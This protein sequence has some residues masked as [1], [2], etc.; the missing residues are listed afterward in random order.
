MDRY[1][2]L[3]PLYDVVSLERPI[4]RAGRVAAVDALRLQPGQTVLVVGSGTGLST[5]LLASHLGPLGHIVGVDAN[6]DMLK[7]AE[8][9]ADLATRQCSITADATTLERSDLP[10]GLGEIHAVLF[11]Y[12]LS[13]MDPW[14]AAWRAVTALLRPGAA[15]AVAD[16]TLPHRGGVLAR[17]AARLLCATGG[18]DIS[19]HPWT[20]LER[21][22]TDVQTREFWGG[23]I[24]VRAGSWPGRI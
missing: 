4:Y 11:V 3:A 13:L 23:H 24:Q 12:S 19:A 21:E 18:S 9:H 10:E 7:A 14:Q 8:R 2:A 6:S 17:T 20:A 15:I 22:C 16:M 5:P 1:T